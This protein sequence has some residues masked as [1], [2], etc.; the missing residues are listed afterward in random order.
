MSASNAPIDLHEYLIAGK[1]IVDR[2][3]QLLQ[4]GGY[5]LPAPQIADGCT[6]LGDKL[7]EY[8]T[9]KLTTAVPQVVTTE[10][11]EKSVPLD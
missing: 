5:A 10:A 9:I 2:Q 6:Y 7:P 4:H 11:I 3:I 1:L 8:R